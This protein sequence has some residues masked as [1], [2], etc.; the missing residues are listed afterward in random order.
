MAFTIKPI[1]VQVATIL[2]R[3]GVY[4]APKPNGLFSSMAKQIEGLVDLDPREEVSTEQLVTKTNSIIKECSANPFTVSTEDDG[5]ILGSGLDVYPELAFN[6][7]KPTVLALVGQIKTLALP[8]VNQLF[9][10]AY[11]TTQELVNTGGIQLTA[12]SD[13]SEHPV[14]SNDS[15]H[16]ILAGVEDTTTATPAISNGVSFPAFDDEIVGEY[17]KTGDNFLDSE[18]EDLLTHYNRHEALEFVYH[19][20]FTPYGQNNH[21]SQDLALEALLALLMA[22]GFLLETPDGGSGV[23]LAEFQL[24]M[25][26]IVNYYGEYIRSLLRMRNSL[27]KTDRLITSFPQAGAEYNAG[28]TIRYLGAAWQRFEDLGGDVDLLFGAYVS[29]DQPRTVSDILDRAEQLRGKW[30]SH[31]QYSQQAR[32]DRFAEA[33]AMQVRKEVIA[34]AK[35]HELKIDTA[36]LIDELETRYALTQDNVYSF[37]RRAICRTL[38]PDTQY[39]QVLENMDSITA[40]NPAISDDNAFELA[41]I[42]TLVAWA[43]THV[44][45]V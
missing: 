25:R 18:V 4:L 3:G 13:L 7:L 40:S 12:V 45:V 36:V 37:A 20:V 27:L 29:S 14:W 31:V 21:Q 11:K 30:A 19:S 1:S 6:E 43:L 32:N 2:A 5:P 34:F 26:R 39:L 38:F 42:D 17:L 35:E 33:F 16:R 23:E 8:T 9:E 41:L 24:A 22:R 10:K 15:L 28:S 44:K